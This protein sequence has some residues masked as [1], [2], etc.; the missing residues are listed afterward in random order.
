MRSFWWTNWLKAFFLL[1]LL[2][3]CDGF[4]I[5]HA[6]G[7]IEWNGR[8]M[9]NRWMER[10]VTVCLS[11]TWCLWN[12]I[13]ILIGVFFWGDFHNCGDLL[14]CINWV[15]LVT[16]LFIIFRAHQ[17]LQKKLFSYSFLNIT[18]FFLICCCIDVKAFSYSHLMQSIYF[19][20]IRVS[21]MPLE[22]ITAVGNNAITGIIPMLW[23]TMFLVY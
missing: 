2:F 19:F 11:K 10:M 7:D 9:G 23:T 20:F 18:T 22:S 12:N 8:A 1:L 15:G 6:D 3:D 17:L 21:S 5:S 16:N 4:S 13:D 14:K